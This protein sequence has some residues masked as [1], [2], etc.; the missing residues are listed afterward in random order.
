MGK[1]SQV[2]HTCLE[3]FKN[4]IKLTF[5]LKIM[6]PMTIFFDSFASKYKAIRI[7]SK[8]FKKNPSKQ[9]VGQT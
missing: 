5:R 7:V 8:R 4:N 1:Y 2:K 9:K 6:Y 3:S